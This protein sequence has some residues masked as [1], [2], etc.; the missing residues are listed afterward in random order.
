MAIQAEEGLYRNLTDIKKLHGTKFIWGQDEQ[1]AVLHL[2]LVEFD[3][4]QFLLLG[5]VCMLCS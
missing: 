5:S 3:G 2:Y 1:E 4:K